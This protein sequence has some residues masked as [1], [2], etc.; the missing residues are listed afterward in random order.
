VQADSGG[1]ADHPQ[2]PSYPRLR[3]FPAHVIIQ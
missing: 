3:A 1:I 2:I